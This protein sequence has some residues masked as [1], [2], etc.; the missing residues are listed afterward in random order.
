MNLRAGF[1][2][3][4]ARDQHVVIATAVDE[5][6]EMDGILHGSVWWSYRFALLRC[7][8]LCTEFSVFS[9]ADSNHNLIPLKIDTTMQSQ[10]QH[11]RVLDDEIILKMHA[12]CTICDYRILNVF[13]LQI[14]TG[15]TRW[16]NI[17]I[18][19]MFKLKNPEM[20]ARTQA[21]DS[22]SSNIPKY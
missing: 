4:L 9:S 17:V 19:F 15:L 13:A 22:Y 20:Q 7:H 8:I 10:S 3:A 6:E 21:N 18:F 14:L 12:D 16:Q 2:V 1:I 11:S 5:S